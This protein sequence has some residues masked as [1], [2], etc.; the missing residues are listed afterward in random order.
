VEVVNNQTEETCDNS[1]VSLKLKWLILFILYYTLSLHSF[2]Y[3]KEAC[4]IGA[5]NQVV[6]ESKLFG[7]F[8]CIVVYV[9]HYLMKLLVNF[10][11]CP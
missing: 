4:D 10:F 7:S 3:F 1:Q 5:C 11:C 8:H 2:C 9:D 6:A